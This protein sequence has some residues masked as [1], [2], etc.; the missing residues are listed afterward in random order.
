[1][2][3]LK[4]WWKKT[5]KVDRKKMAELGVSAVLSYGLISNLN[6]CG[7]LC[8]AKIIFE[9]KNGV[10]PFAPGQ[11]KAFL[12]I[13]GGLWAAM[14]FVR[15]LRVWLALGLT[16]YFDKLIQKISAKFGVK[17]SVALGITVF[18]VNILGT[19]AFLGTG[20][21]LSSVY[22]GVPLVLPFLNKAAAG[23]V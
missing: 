20:L 18:F 12:A 16:P 21:Y 19:F 22:T 4:Q 2:G 7:T 3:R 10:S 17:K 6:Y 9:K 8:A 13:Y 23:A 15:P 14:N 11:W 5:A 1:M